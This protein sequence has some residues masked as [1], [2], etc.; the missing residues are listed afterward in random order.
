MPVS[1]LDSVN[2]AS[3]IRLRNDSVAGTSLRTSGKLASAAAHDRAA[4]PLR[5]GL[6]NWDPKLNADLS[7][8]QRT[9]EFLDQSAA[10]L[11]GL[12]L[13]LSAKLTGRLQQNGTLQHKVRQFDDHW[14]QRLAATGGSLDSQLAYD[15]AAAPSQRFTVRG[16]TL[17][18]LQSGARETLTFSLGAGQPLHSVIVEPGLSEEALVQRFDN[19]LAPAQIRVAKGDGGALVFSVA[20]SAWSAVRDT[21]AIKGDGMRFPTGQ[22]NRA[23]TDAEPPALQPETWQISDVESLRKTLQQVVQALAHVRQARE[24]VNRA[25]NDAASRAHAAQS[26]ESA[27]VITK[28]TQDFL[29]IS[30]QPEYQIFSS[31]VAAVVG[32]SRSRVLSLL[33]LRT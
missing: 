1:P 24:A 25:L 4:A 3:A 27:A 15:G 32:I 2:S 7:N 23:R 26:Q 28:L 6:R 16:L 18:T 13:E 17:Q 30:T 29:G 12:K 9:L 33:A 19:A 14:Q 11:Q 31:V 5:R 8:A 22:F 21:L 10:R 20:E